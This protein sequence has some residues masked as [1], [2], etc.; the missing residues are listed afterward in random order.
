MDA[1]CNGLKLAPNKEF[2]M[3]LDISPFTRAI[4]RLDEGMVR[5]LTDTS[6]TQIRDGLAK[7]RQKKAERGLVVLLKVRISF[8]ISAQ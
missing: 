2:R 3:T 5:Y 4:Q 6:D 8:P 7:S 1:C